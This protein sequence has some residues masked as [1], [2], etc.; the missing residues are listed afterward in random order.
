VRILYAPYAARAPSLNGQGS[1]KDYPWPK[2]LA[3]LLEK[4]HEVIQVGGNGDVQVAKDARLNLSFKEL[5]ELIES[6]DTGICVDSYLGHYYWYLNRRAI[7]LFGISDP[8]IFGHP[9]NL[10]LLK[11]RSYLRPQQFDLY[12]TNQYCPEAFV[13]PKEVIDALKEFTRISEKSA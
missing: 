5:G 11:D 9:E 7:V 4:D 3:E 1:P 2:E 6:S 8:M 10:N 12:Y 13:K